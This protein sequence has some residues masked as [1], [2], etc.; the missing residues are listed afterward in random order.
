MSDVPEAT[1]KPEDTGIRQ[2][3]IT[4]DK[5]KDITSVSGPIG[6]KSLCYM[7]LKMAEKIVDDFKTPAPDPDVAPKP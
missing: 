3:I 7:M 1:P 5:N 2:L 6:A 4:Y